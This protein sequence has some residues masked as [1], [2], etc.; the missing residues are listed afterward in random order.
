M[1]SLQHSTPRGIQFLGV[2]F[3]LTDEKEEIR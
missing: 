1:G 3:E 2:L